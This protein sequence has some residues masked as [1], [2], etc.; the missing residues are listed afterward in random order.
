M[1]VTSTISD[2][3]EGQWKLVQNQVKT[4]YYIPHGS[5]RVCATFERGELERHVEMPMS[6][7][8][9]LLVALT[10]AGSPVYTPLLGEPCE[11]GSPVAQE[12]HSAFP[13][14]A[15]VRSVGSYGRSE[16]GGISDGWAGS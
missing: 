8:I 15:P 7:L 11:H 16:I 6:A 5:T 9:G 10:H 14:A 1:R 4:S 12:T 13:A 3:T 2:L